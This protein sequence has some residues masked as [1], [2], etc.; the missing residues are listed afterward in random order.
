[1]STNDDIRLRRCLA[2]KIAS[3]DISRPYVWR[4]KLSPSDF[5][6]LHNAIA[7]SIASHGGDI[8]HLLTADYARHVIVY[9]AEWYK[10]CYAAGTADDKAIDPN[11]DQLKVLWRA[12][13]I[14]TDKYVYATADGSRRLW[15][16][17]IY[18]LGGLAIRHE[19]GK[20]DDRFLRALC[21]VLHGENSTL[22]NIADESRAVAFRSSISQKHSLYE[23]LT[24]IVNN[25][26]PFSKEDAGG[27]ARTLV[28]R[29]RNANDEVLKQK[30]RFEWVV[31]YD[32]GYPS[33]QRQ[34]RLWL[35]PEM[36]G[37]GLHHYLRY[38]RMLLWGFKNPD[39]IERLFVSLRFI[40]GEK[41]VDDL[42]FKC[43][44]ISYVNTG[45][46]YTG[47]V[48]LGVK[49]YGLCSNVPAAHFT[50]IEVWA[51]DNEGNRRC[52]QEYDCKEYMQL[53]RVSPYDDEWTSRQSAQKET[54]VVFSK[55][56]RI[57]ADELNATIALLPFRNRKFGNSA[58]YGWCDIYDRVTIEDE[59]GSLVT[60]YNR[61]G[62]YSISTKLYRDC[63]C[64]ATGGT[65]KH[66]SE[67]DDEDFDATEE[68]LP[69]IFGKSDIE[70]YHFE[71][72]DDAKNELAESIRQAEAIEFKA[73]GHWQQWTDLQ[74]PEYGALDLRITV[75]GRQMPYRVFYMPAVEPKHPIVRDFKAAKIVYSDF[76]D[77][78]V[79]QQ[80]I[81]DT[82]DFG[83]TPTAPT[84]TIQVG[85]SG[86]Y[87]EI[88]VYRPTLVR[89]ICRDGVVVKRL[90][91]EDVVIPY[92]LKDS[93]TINCFTEHGFQAYRCGSL[94]PIFA[95]LENNDFADFQLSA[96]EK[97]TQI[98][99][100]TLDYYAPPCLKVWLGDPNHESQ[101]VK[102][103]RWNY[104]QS[105]E[106][107]E[108][109]YVAS[110]EPNTV[111]FQSMIAQRSIDCVA[112]V[113]GGFSVFKYKKQQISAVKCFDVALHHGI[114]FFI[115]LPLTK[116]SDYKAEL[117]EP[118]L[119]ARGGVLSDADKK[120][121]LRFSEEFNFDWQTYKID[122]QSSII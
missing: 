106:P 73:A 61:T 122:I 80:A 21:R 119:A 14:N 109:D 95:H 120:G 19:L 97:G 88:E 66:F 98:Q 104:W 37:E 40:D 10:R 27:E 108:C 43:P 71:T 62:Y 114:Y 16:Y 13:G 5:S 63:I 34:L 117:Y 69:L 84:L 44:T 107:T 115:L 103:F 102:F 12:S 83:D 1:M 105:T 25:K 121:L 38:D 78:V 32:N 87:A 4:L 53:W 101:D 79:T 116:I 72:K 41:I 75:Q 99:A 111:I 70:I 76:C 31:N 45:E 50:K 81:Q 39:T 51:C 15:Q 85:N 8:A 58:N 113:R 77:G 7:A 6:E 17:S 42:N 112:P 86:D 100:T 11:T 3:L 55:S 48:A 9:L 82:F 90:H 22:E 118:L 96:W 91:N 18:V 28:E 57:L 56:C 92:I 26:F 65:V 93:L 74:Q 54:A 36:A 110:T 23:F 67:S 29:I 24:E 94:S 60:L 49:D 2:D 64:Y 68:L 59:Q 30:F 33:M 52:I 46:E 35:N 20:T 89:E 47:F